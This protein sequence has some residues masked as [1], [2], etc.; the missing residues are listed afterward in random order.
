M[1]RIPETTREWYERYE[2]KRTKAYYNFQE[3]G[4]PR[5]DR[6]ENEYGAIADAFMSKLREEADRDDTLKKRRVN[7]DYVV[8]RLHKSEYTK[9]EVIEMLNNAVWW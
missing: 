3:T 9:D 8:E 4:E 6:Q 1:A 2:A 7:C 5:Y